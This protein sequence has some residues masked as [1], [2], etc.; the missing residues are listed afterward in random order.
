MGAGSGSQPREERAG[1]REGGGG[2]RL[3][4][5]EQREQRSGGANRTSTHARHRREWQRIDPTDRSDACD[6]VV[7]MAARAACMAPT[8]SALPSRVDRRRERLAQRTPNPGRSGPGRGGG[9]RGRTNKQT[10]ER[11]NEQTLARRSCQTFG[12]RGC[13]YIGERRGKGGES[14]GESR[15]RLALTG[16]TKGGCCA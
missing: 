13:I 2:K 3:R 1:G 11:T 10:T 8:P 14:G 9:G 4:R 16:G 5:G 7:V 15:R 12:P 6:T